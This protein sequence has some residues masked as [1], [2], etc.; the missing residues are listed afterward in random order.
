MKQTK[1]FFFPS[2]PFFFSSYS[3]VVQLIKT[4]KVPKSTKKYVFDERSSFLVAQW[5]NGAI[6]S[7]S[8]RYM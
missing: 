5:K 8:S 4:Q 6:K 1:H 7:V 3:I 2:S